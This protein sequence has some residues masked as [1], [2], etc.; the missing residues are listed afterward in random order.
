MRRIALALA[1]A[2]APALAQSPAEEL[3]PDT[4]GAF[5]PLDTAGRVAMLTA[6]QPLGDEINAADQG[7]ARQWTEQVAAACHGH[8]D[9]PLSEA[10]ASALGAD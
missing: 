9:R 6:I 10:A 7:A 2:A 1:L 4:C 8:P 5:L 3:N